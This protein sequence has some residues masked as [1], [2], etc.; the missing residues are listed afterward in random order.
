MERV[1]QRIPE[2]LLLEPFLDHRTI[3]LCH[4]VHE[5]RAEGHLVLAQV[6]APVGE[7]NRDDGREGT[8]RAGVLYRVATNLV[9]GGQLHQVQDGSAHLVDLERGISGHFLVAEWP[10]WPSWQG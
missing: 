4:F 1:L 10:E 9:A 7:K 5:S 8:P 3:E 6:P 2:L